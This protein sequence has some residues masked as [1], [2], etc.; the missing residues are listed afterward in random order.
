MN[1]T[2]TLLERVRTSLDSHSDYAVSKALQISRQRMSKY[3]RGADELHDENIICRAA[4]IVGDDPA[5]VLARIRRERATS[6]QAKAAWQR[7]E[8]LAKKTAL[9]EAA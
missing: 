7:L 4:E 9:R 8:N 6:D 2:Q 3:M 1:S 5:F